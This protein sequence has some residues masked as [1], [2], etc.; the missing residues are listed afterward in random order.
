[1]LAPLC[2]RSKLALECH[3]AALNQAQLYRARRF[4]GLGDRASSLVSLAA[5]AAPASIR[6]ALAISHKFLLSYA[7]YALAPRPII[8]SDSP[9]PASLLETLDA[10]HRGGAGSGYYLLEC[11][12][13]NNSTIRRAAI[14]GQ[15]RIVLGDCQ[16]IP[17][18]PCRRTFGLSNPD[19]LSTAASLFAG[20]THVPLSSAT[21]MIKAYALQHASD[22]LGSCAA[23]SATKGMILQMPGAAVASLIPNIP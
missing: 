20:S 15:D 18:S 10:I 14:C 3:I 6:R 4:G 13:D 1:L 19:V 16:Q 23:A 12:G 2:S 7:T 8:G 9:C 21:D 17:K 11:T 5:P 22:I